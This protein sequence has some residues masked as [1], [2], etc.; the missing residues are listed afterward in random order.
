MI[1]Y[2][3]RRLVQ[4]L[5]VVL[6]AAI[7]TYFLFNI[8]PGGPLTGL[9]QQQ[10]RL[11]KEDV[12]R[13]RAQ[14]E[15]DLYWPVRFSRWLTGFPTGPVIVAGREWF[16]SVP[17]G[18]YLPAGDGAGCDDYVY[19]NEIP[20]LHPEILS[21]AGVLRGDF[22]P[23]T[24]ITPGRPV[25]A[26]I[27]SRLGATLELMISS[28]I[29]SLAIGIPI[30]VLSAVRQYSRFD[31][32][33]TTLAFVG[34]AMPVFFFGLLLILAFSVMPTFLEDTFPWIPSL[35]SGLREA[36]RPYEVASWL[37]KVQPGSLVDRGLHLFMP[38]IVLTFFGMA[39]WSRFVRSSMLEVLRQDYVRT[40]RSKG[41]VERTVI[42]KHA[43]RNALIP[44]VT[45]LVLQIPNIFAGAIITETVFAWPGMGRLYFDALNRSDW[46][47]ALAFIFITAV[48]T[49][50]ATLLGDLLYTVVDP[51][52]KYS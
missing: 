38:L 18:C 3:I 5:F 51:R 27:T 35:P 28:L 36:I 40:A 14:Y 37:P 52:I 32:F 39:T 19:L 16:A 31:Y 11:T 20:V 43:L 41:L 47:V 8:A 6:L 49:V 33:F 1:S 48:L 15:L 25:S 45:I 10:Q 24:V 21:S 34:S 7:A 22:G 26:L 13:I 50:I 9:Q 4:M 17:V 42:A 30:G 23:S 46:P 44:F 29:L 12:A 2:L